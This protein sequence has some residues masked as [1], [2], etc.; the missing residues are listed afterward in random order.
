LARYKQLRVGPSILS[1]RLAQAR[2]LKTVNPK[3][4]EHDAA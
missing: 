1:E 4:I 3:V 2:A